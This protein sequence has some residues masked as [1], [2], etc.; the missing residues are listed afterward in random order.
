MS[1]K[2]DLTIEEYK[3]MLLDEIEE[4]EEICVTH[5]DT[6]SQFSFFAI[7]MSYIAAPDI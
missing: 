5:T 3:E 4:D 1:K 2:K 7:A 6:Q